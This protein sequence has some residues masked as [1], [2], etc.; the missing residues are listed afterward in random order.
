MDGGKLIE[1]WRVLN[2]ISKGSY[3]YDSSLRTIFEKRVNDPPWRKQLSDF[4]AQA[5]RF[6]MK[7]Q[8]C[9]RE[10]ELADSTKVCCR[11]WM[12]YRAHRKVHHLRATFTYEAGCTRGNDKR[13]A[14][15][16]RDLHSPPSVSRWPATFSLSLSFCVILILRRENEFSQ[17][18][19]LSDTDFLAFDRSMFLDRIKSSYHPRFFKNF[20][21]FGRFSTR[22]LP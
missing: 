19:N 13:G 16:R 8:A 2:F 22:R 11:A 7:C 15:T 10:M 3:K 5:V 6:S 21:N 12:E 17:F 4:F 14:I 1:R 9:S 18:Y 20:N